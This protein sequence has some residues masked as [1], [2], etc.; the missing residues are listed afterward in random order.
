MNTSTMNSGHDKHPGLEISKIVVLYVLGWAFIAGG[1]GLSLTQVLDDGFWPV[2]FGVV[3]L[4]PG[5]ILWSLG[6]RARLRMASR[7]QAA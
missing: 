2:P 1:V 6:T 5:A 7:R 4:V 3:F